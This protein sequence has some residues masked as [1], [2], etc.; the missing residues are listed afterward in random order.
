MISLQHYQKLSL[1]ND[2]F[3]CRICSQT[4]FRR[5]HMEM[6][7]K[8]KHPSE[9]ATS[10][11]SPIDSTSGECK[12]APDFDLD[13]PGKAQRDEDLQPPINQTSALKTI[14]GEVRE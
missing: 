13:L 1:K 7:V 9:V 6:H 10:V 12:N 8:Y 5:Q 2:S 3:K 11:I 14:A 4:F